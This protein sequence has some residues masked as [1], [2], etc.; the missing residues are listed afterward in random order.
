MNVSMMNKRANWLVEGDYILIPMQYAGWV[1]DVY[2]ETGDNVIAEKSIAKMPLFTVVLDAK[3]I[4]PILQK[5]IELTGLSSEE[6]R[7]M[8]D[9]KL[10]DMRKFIGGVYKLNGQPA[11]YD[12]YERMSLPLDATIS[13]DSTQVI[14]KKELRNSH[15]IKL[16]DADGNYLYQLYLKIP[17]TEDAIVKTCMFFWWLDGQHS[18]SAAGT[19]RNDLDGV[20]YY[21]NYYVYLDLSAE[22]RTTLFDIKNFKQTKAA[23]SQRIDHEY[24]KGS[25]DDERNEMYELI[26]I[27]AT[28]R[29]KVGDSAPEYSALYDCVKRSETDTRKL[30]TRQQLMYY[31]MMNAGRSKCRGAEEFEVKN[32]IQVMNNIGADT[33]DKRAK[34]IFDTLKI[35]NFVH[36]EEDLGENLFDWSPK[37]LS[38]S[39]KAGV[40]FLMQPVFEVMAEK[41]LAPEKAVIAGLHVIMRDD[42]MGSNIYHFDGFKNGSGGAGCYNMVMDLREHFMKKCEKITENEIMERGLAELNKA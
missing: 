24:M 27:L 20:H 33:N 23:S 13:V 28:Q 9:K 1:V 11:G 36:R 2:D 35:M 21:M 4:A 40:F 37:H 31:T 18:S 3:L 10:N 12:A 34:L 42:V 7:R 19:P 22:E 30:V 39:K 16:R 8:L 14:V 5:R 6:Q 32:T 15:G 41:H 25:W 29:I 26:N 38:N 17:N